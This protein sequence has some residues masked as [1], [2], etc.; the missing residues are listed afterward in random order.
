MR[1]VESLEIFTFMGFFHPNHIRF[2][3]ESTEELCLLTLNSD[4]NFEENLALGLKNDMRN[5]MNIFVSIDKS[6]RLNFNLLLLSIVY[7]VSATKLQ[8]N[9]LL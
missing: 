4:A 5:L 7:K 3:L 2:R 9:Y 6:E 1:A 8:I